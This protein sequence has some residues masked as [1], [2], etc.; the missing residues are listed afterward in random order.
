MQF[1]LK[2]PCSV[3]I[4]NEIAQKL[5]C[6]NIFPFAKVDDFNHLGFRMLGERSC[7]IW[8]FTFWK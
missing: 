8:L 2:N 1:F 3:A 6:G 4:A 7:R 5:S